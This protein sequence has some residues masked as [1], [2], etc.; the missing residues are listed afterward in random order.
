MELKDFKP[1]DLV[2]VRSGGPV[3]T[4]EK[5]GTSA[6]FGEDFVSCVWFEK[7]GNKQVAQDR[8]FTPAQLDQVEKPHTSASVGI[9]RA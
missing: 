6:T 3:M 7:V 4:V 5:T 1:G 9:L 2:Q 8:S